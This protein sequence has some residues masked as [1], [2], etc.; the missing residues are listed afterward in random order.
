MS[1]LG[2]GGRIVLGERIPLNFYSLRGVNPGLEYYEK[3]D[4]PFGHDGGIIFNAPPGPGVGFLAEEIGD[5]Y[6]AIYIY[7]AETG[8]QNKFC[9]EE[10]AP[11][12]HPELEEFYSV[13]ILLGIPGNGSNWP[14]GSWKNRKSPYRGP[15]LLAGLNQG[16]FVESFPLVQ[17]TEC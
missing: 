8:Y 11:L 15:K 9:Q 1:N 3:M 17:C 10:G 4:S 13:N 14:R 5:I 16:L 6:S 2:R 7:P 12:Y